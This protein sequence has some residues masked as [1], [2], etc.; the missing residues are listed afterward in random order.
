MAC[1]NNH[2]FA[3]RSG[4]WAELVREGSSLPH[5]AAWRN[6]EYSLLR[7]LTC[8]WQVGAGFQLELTG[9]LSTCTSPWLSH[10]WWLGSKNEHIKRQKVETANFLSLGPRNR[11]SLSSAIFYQSRILRAHSQGQGIQNFLCEECQIIWGLC[12]KTATIFNQY[13]HLEA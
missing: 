9:G 10:T 3:H 13:R 8:D 4:I 11:L 1:N 6:L 5:G 2:L 12:S 7:R